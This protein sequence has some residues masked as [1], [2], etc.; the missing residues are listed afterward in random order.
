MFESLWQYGIYCLNGTEHLGWQSRPNNYILSSFRDPVKRLVSHYAFWKQGADKPENK[1]KEVIDFL[2]WVEFNKDFLNDY[3]AKNFMITRKNFTT[4]IFDKKTYFDPDFLSVNL[5][6]KIVFNRISEVNIFLKD[7]Q[8]N[9]ATC[10]AVK[11]KICTDFS[12]IYPPSIKEVEI[13]ARRVGAESTEIFNSLSESD[14][15]YLYS[16]SPLDSEIYNSSWLFFNKG[17]N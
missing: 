16:L 2:T 9:L 10:E 15:Q 13:G 8:L 3:Q 1:P 4:N 7:S 12:I 6:R 17:Q 14:K 5:D 11:N